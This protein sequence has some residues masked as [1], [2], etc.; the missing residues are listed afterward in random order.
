MQSFRIV[1][2]QSAL[3]GRTVPKLV[4]TLSIA[5]SS[6]SQVPAM[7]ILRLVRRMFEDG[8]FISNV[9]EAQGFT[10]DLLRIILIG[11]YSE[12]L[13]QSMRCGTFCVKDLRGCVASTF[14]REVWWG[15]TLLHEIS[16]M[17]DL[18]PPNFEAFFGAMTSF[19]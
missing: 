15:G 14:D 16:C 7:R 2:Y 1:R 11:N 8:P 12:A 10:C 17:S 5:V 6:A 13:G 3:G 18:N 19:G 9:S 4:R